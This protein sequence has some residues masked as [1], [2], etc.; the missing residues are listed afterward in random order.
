MSF[1]LAPPER[2]TASPRAANVAGDRLADVVYMADEGDA[3]SRRRRGS[4]TPIPA[5]TIHAAP[6]AI[7]T[8][9]T[10]NTFA[11][12]IHSGAAQ[13]STSHAR[14]GS[15]VAVLLLNVVWSPPAARI[16]S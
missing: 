9:P 10:E 3:A 5:R 2:C 1:S 12:G 14:C 6:T 15:T 8:S 16:A 7:S 4:R 11:A 13:R